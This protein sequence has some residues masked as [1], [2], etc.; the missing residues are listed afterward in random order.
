MS[1]EHDPVMDIPLDTEM[2]IESNVSVENNDTEFGNSEYVLKKDQDLIVNNLEKTI[3]DNLDRIDQDNSILVA[4][5]A[6][7]HNDPALE[8]LS[9][10]LNELI[11]VKNKILQ[12]NYINRKLGMEAISLMDDFPFKNPNFYTTQLSKTNYSYTLES[13]GTTI[14][15]T[16]TKILNWLKK[17]WKW[18][19]DKFRATVKKI[20]EKLRAR[21]DDHVKKC[22]LIVEKIDKVFTETKYPLNNSSEKVIDNFNDLLNWVYKPDGKERIVWQRFFIHPNEYVAD[23]ILENILQKTFIGIGDKTVKAAGIIEDVLKQIRGLL[24]KYDLS[25]DDNI[26][27]MEEISKKI[28]EFSNSPDSL[29]KVGL[30]VKQSFDDVKGLKLPNAKITDSYQLFLQKLL[31]IKPLIDSMS[32]TNDK[33]SDLP[34]AKLSDDIISFS[35]KVNELEDDIYP[36]FLNYLQDWTKF[37][38]HNLRILDTIAN[39]IDRSSNT[40]SDTYETFIQLSVGMGEIMKKYESK[41]QW[42]ENGVK[43]ITDLKAIKV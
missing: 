18:L 26:P 25:K 1:I 16:G 23:I 4:D 36:E 41:M 29:D 2:N 3:N 12:T 8:S 37:I 22:E 9:F 7:P 35:Q 38:L 11:R 13:L 19:S 21:K 40:L 17:I 33:I 31:K 10:K 43:L 39:C 6:G 14:K 24:N 30:E 5:E 28:T 34:L 42:N 27:L 15:D 32:E 20:K